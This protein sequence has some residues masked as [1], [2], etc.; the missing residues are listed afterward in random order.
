MTTFVTLLLAVIV[1]AAAG[2]AA[3]LCVVHL[4]KVQDQNKELMP[5]VFGEED[6]DGE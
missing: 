4:Y 5:I 1:A 6:E 2:T 3:S